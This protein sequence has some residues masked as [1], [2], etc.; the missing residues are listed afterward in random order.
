MREPTLLLQTYSPLELL[1]ENSPFYCYD[2]YN[3]D[4]RLETLGNELT[5]THI[6]NSPPTFTE[7]YTYVPKPLTNDDILIVRTDYTVGFPSINL[8]RLF[9]TP[10]PAL[11]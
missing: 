1:Q 4:K 6:E 8:P 10:D 11:V 7:N 5:M 9:T 3:R 2:R